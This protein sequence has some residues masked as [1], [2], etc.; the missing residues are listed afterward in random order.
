M[1]SP[2]SYSQILKESEYAKNEARTLRE[3]NSMLI[4]ELDDMRNSMATQA[5]IMA[6]LKLELREY[7]SVHVRNTTEIL[8][9]EEC[10]RK[11]NIGVDNFCDSIE[12][13]FNQIL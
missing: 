4:K 8:K 6:S 13:R 3:V 9:L 12:K 5:C 7:V 11:H 10:L 2:K 1:Q